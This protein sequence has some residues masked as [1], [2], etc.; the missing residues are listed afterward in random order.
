MATGVNNEI[1]LQS[2]YYLF[3]LYTVIFLGLISLIINWLL[4]PQMGITGAALATLMAFCA[5]NLIR[6][7]FLWYRFNLQPFSYKNLLTI[8]WAVVCYFL[9]LL[10]PASPYLMLNLIL[11]SLFIS[12]SFGGF[13]YYFQISPEM[14]EVGKNLGRKMRIWK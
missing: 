8:F 9:C 5:Y 14:N 12:L 1:L 6:F 4:I 10:I 2:N 13:V 7:I 11:K 3:N